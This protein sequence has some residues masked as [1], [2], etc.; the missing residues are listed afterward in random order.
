[1]YQETNEAEKRK[2]WA[3]IAK[4]VL[5]AEFVEEEKS[6]SSTS[7]SSGANRPTI[8]STTISTHEAESI[9]EEVRK[10]IAR[11][12]P[13]IQTMMAQIGSPILGSIAQKS[14]ETLTSVIDLTEST[15]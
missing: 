10:M 6:T 4:H 2:G 15:P 5:G 8:G 14:G 12:F 13:G 7:P 3:Q 9:K 11:A 1:M